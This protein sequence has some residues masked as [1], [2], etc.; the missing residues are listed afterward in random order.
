MKILFPFIILLFCNSVFADDLYTWTDR[1]GEVH[2]TT[3]PPPAGANVK[4]QS[5]F[6]RSSAQEIRQFE[7]GRRQKQRIIDA[8]RPRPTA[9]TVKSEPVS[10][11]AAPPPPE[12]K[13]KKVTHIA[14][15]PQTG[16][17]I[18]VIPIH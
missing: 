9:E 13:K 1:K 3:T 16:Q 4:D 12:K 7:D 5:S 14:V 11:V 2:I 8:Q 18:P 15:D 10:P 6:Q 17:V